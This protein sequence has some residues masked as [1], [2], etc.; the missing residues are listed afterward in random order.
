V[1]SFPQMTLAKLR[2]G[3]GHA[4]YTPETILPYVIL[5]FP[6]FL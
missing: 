4:M 3:R 1:H 2:G 6:N 5:Y